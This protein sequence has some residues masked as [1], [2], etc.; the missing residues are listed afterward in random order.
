MGDI[1]QHVPEEG[2]QHVY[3]SRGEFEI[4]IAAINATLL[5]DYDVIIGIKEGGRNPTLA[6][7]K[8]RGVTLLW[9]D[10]NLNPEFTQ[11]DL[12][13]AQHVMLVDD[14]LDT[15]GTVRKA[16]AALVPLMPK[17]ATCTLVTLHKS[18]RAGEVQ[19]EFFSEYPFLEEYHYGR[20]LPSR[21]FVDYF[22]EMAL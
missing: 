16:L 14:I 10:R 17:G 7:H 11:E 13:S 19:E 3:Y 21:F 1:P 20:T 9:F 5:L 22:W 4:D 2:Q 6:L 8:D 12:G 18:T 15:G